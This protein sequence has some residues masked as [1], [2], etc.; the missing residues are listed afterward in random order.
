MIF[1]KKK[2]KPEAVKESPAPKKVKSL[3]SI[4]RDRVLTAEGWRRQVESKIPSPS[5]TRSK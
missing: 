3:Q 1:F 2:Q 5:K 4:V